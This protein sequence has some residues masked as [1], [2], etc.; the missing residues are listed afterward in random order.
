MFGKY[1]IL[2][3][4]DDLLNDESYS[5][6]S[7][8]Y[9]ASKYIIILDILFKIYKQV[10]RKNMLPKS[11]ELNKKAL[12]KEFLFLATPLSHFHPS[13]FAS[14][15]FAKTNLYTG[16]RESARISKCIYRCY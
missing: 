1:I 15:R 13:H 10:V 12:P 5:A 7:S 14:A 2:I 6:I 16:E 4:D 9:N 8:D 11:T 3:G